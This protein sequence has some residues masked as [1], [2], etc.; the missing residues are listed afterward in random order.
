MPP[1][2]CP[3]LPPSW[4]VPQVFRKR[5]GEKPGR[6]RA[7]NADGHLLLVLHSPPTS[8]HEVREGRLFWRAPD[9]K[10]TPGAMRH[11]QSPV[12]ELLDEYDRALDELQQ[13][14]ADADESRDYFDMLNR[15]TPLVRAL[16]NAHRVL[17][18]AREAVPED[19]QIILLRDRAYSL[20]RAAELLH[21]DAKHGLE[22]EMARRSEEHSAAAHRMSVSA[23]RLN[24]L[25]AFFFPVATLAGI[26][27]MNL[28]HGLED[29][30]KASGPWPLLAVLAGG[31]VGGALLALFVTRKPR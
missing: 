25:V 12:D 31:L 17:Q 9:G 19:R 30:D 6:Q 26:L 2:A 20:A 21:D 15:L 5:L 13:A 10:W 7:M 4:D 1:A 23:H 28:R 8:D 11:G 29:A 27:G 3:L 22:F 24:V 18:D 16:R 14:L